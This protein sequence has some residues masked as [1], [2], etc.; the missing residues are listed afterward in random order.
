MSVPGSIAL[1]ARSRNRNSVPGRGGGS[2]STGATGED[3]DVIGVWSQQTSQRMLKIAGGLASNVALTDICGNNTAALLSAIAA[4][5]GTDP[6]LAHTLFKSTAS[7]VS[8][9]ACIS[10]TV[11]SVVVVT[12]ADR[13]AAGI[14]ARAIHIYMHIMYI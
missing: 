12:C 8:I 14:G 1:P 7:G 10:F 2:V 5:T 9:Y 11:T 6:M 4:Q 3:T 13:N